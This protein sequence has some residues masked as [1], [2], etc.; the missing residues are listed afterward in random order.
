MHF[1]SLGTIIIVACMIFVNFAFARVLIK[2][3]Y[4]HYNCTHRHCVQTAKVWMTQSMF[5]QQPRN[6]ILRCQ[7]SWWNSNGV[8]PDE[9]KTCAAK[10]RLSVA[11]SDAP[12]CCRVT[13]KK[14]NS[15]KIKF[16]TYAKIMVNHMPNNT[17]NCSLSIVLTATDQKPQKSLKRSYYS[18]SRWHSGNV[19]VGNITFLMIFAVFDPSPLTRWINC[20]F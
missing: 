7:L 18:A 2:K 20:S 14:T 12:E 19:M 8:S 5:T 16:G 6:F 3:S 10:D 13:A 17:K 15:S 9:S 1:V 11:G 4:Y